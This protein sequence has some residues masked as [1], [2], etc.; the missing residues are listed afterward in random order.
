MRTYLILVLCVFG[1][2]SWVDATDMA[3]R[4]DVDADGVEGAIDCDDGDADVR[5]PSTW[6]RDH[7]E[8]GFG[9]PN[10]SRLACEKPTSFVDNNADCD[11]SDAQLN[12]EDGDSDGASTCDG[13]CDDADFS[14]NLQD[15]DRDGYSTCDDIPDCD[16]GD[17]AVY[18]GATEV[19]GDG[20]DQN[21]DLS[22]DCFVD[23]DEDGARDELATEPSAILLCSEAG[24]T[25]EDAP[26]D[27]DDQ[28]PMVAPGA[29]EWCNGEDD[30]CDGLV[31]EDP[32]DPLTWHEDGDGDGA[33]SELEIIEACLGPLGYLP[34]ATEFDCDDGDPDLNQRDDDG[35]GQTSCGGD[36]DDDDPLLNGNDNDEDGF[37]SCEDDCDDSN[38]AVFPG[39]VERCNEIDDDCD[40]TIDQNAVDPRAWY[41]DSDEDGAIDPDVLIL[42]CKQ[43]TGFYEASGV[44]DCD[45]ADEVLNQRDDDDDGQTSC[46]GDC[47]DNEKLVHGLDNDDDGFSHCDEPNPDC[48]DTSPD[49]YPGAVEIWRNGVD[50][51]CDDMNDWDEDG[52]G[53]VEDR[54]SEQASG[55]APNVGDCDDEDASIHPG[56][57]EFCGD[58][59]VD[60]DGR[61]YIDSDCDGTHYQP[62]TVSA[63]L[64]GGGAFDLSGLFLTFDGEVLDGSESLTLLK[65]EYPDDFDEI[66]LCARTDDQP[67]LVSLDVGPLVEDGKLRIVGHG[68]PIIDMSPGGYAFSATNLSSGFGFILENL[69]FVGNVGN[70]IIDISSDQNAV[71]PATVAMLNVDF[72]DVTPWVPESRIDM[73]VLDG[74]YAA[75]NG[76]TVT[77]VDASSGVSTFL[78]CEECTLDA[79]QLTIDGSSFEQRAL[80]LVNANAQLGA[81][82]ATGNHGEADGAV[83]RIDGGVVAFTTDEVIRDEDLKPQDAGP[84]IGLELPHF[85]RLESNTSDGS[86]GAIYVTG[87]AVVDIDIPSI[88]NNVSN[89]LGGAVFVDSGSTL[90]LE[91]GTELEGN[92]A[93][94]GG[95]IYSEGFVDMHD[96]V[97]RA[98]TATR[99][100]AFFVGDGG[101]L[102]SVDSQW[103]GNGATDGGAVYLED[104]ALLAHH[105]ADEFSGNGALLSGGALYVKG[106]IAALVDVLFTGNAASAGTMIFLESASVVASNSHYVDDCLLCVTAVEID[107]DS[108]MTLEPKAWSAPGIGVQTNVLPDVEF[109][110]LGGSKYICGLG[111]AQGCVEVF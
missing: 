54:Y 31:D 15:V 27:C 78:T 26:V 50:E 65:E 83:A 47:N 13:D 19:P 44:P 18:P 60:V 64:A 52:D 106:S 98:N 75:L 108:V 99:G 69:S 43:P 34:P 104:G 17:A 70:S 46:D 3:A 95:A 25:L 94:S 58:F 72:G 22:E 28:D 85:G 76:V 81:I 71:T 14:R 55:S 11:D 63:M 32:L 41:A 80:D 102:V 82:D 103:D 21:C 30:N 9:D 12:P 84:I 107:L 73:V 111:L 110:P 62:G 57:I 20:R 7:D 77:D 61:Y 91:N 89:A 6:Y 5:E 48:D 51:N 74:V 10:R 49:I 67:W 53:Y 92:R 66:G 4:I 101:S 1:A 59:A 105:D 45:D 87:N 88:F 37:V 97:L 33:G 23:Q 38:S 42:A 8:D 36:C 39:A 24:L 79:D 68:N 29:A 40:D 16:D 90:N 2:C 93:V 109:K 56:A 35:D 96:V 86:G 100:G